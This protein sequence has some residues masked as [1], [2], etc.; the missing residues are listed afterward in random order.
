MGN[1]RQ[2]ELGAAGRFAPTA[3]KQRG[4]NA[5]LLVLSPFSSFKQTTG[6]DSVVNSE[7]CFTED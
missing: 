7:R 5:S 3:G 1:S 6:D 4:M 2:W